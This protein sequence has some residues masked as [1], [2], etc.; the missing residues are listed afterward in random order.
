MAD[1][2]EKNSSHNIDRLKSDNAF[3]LESM[4]ELLEKNSIAEE[5]VKS[6]M[7]KND[8]LRN[9]IKRATRMMSKDMGLKVMLGEAQKSNQ[10][11][12]KEVDELRKAKAILKKDL[13]SATKLMAAMQKREERQAM[14]ED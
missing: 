10:E 14:A 4:Q 13:A 9:D 8:D 7:K 6:Q 1:A 12:T 2:E 5:K 11:L 3:L